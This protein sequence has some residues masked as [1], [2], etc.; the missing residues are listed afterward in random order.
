MQLGLL[1][2]QAGRALRVAIAAPVAAAFDPE[3]TR[4]AASLPALVRAFESEDDVEATLTIRQPVLV[5]VPMAARVLIVSRAGEPPR[6]VPIGTEPLLVGRA[7]SSD[8]VLPAEEVS[9]MHCRLVPGDAGLTVI[10]LQ[11][12][13][14]TSLDGQRVTAQ[15]V[16]LPNSE[17]RV[18]PYVLTCRLALTM[19][20]ANAATRSRRRGAG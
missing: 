14:G 16:M 1:E 19:P 12:T 7:P 4:L 15:S 5:P 18:G 2:R 17:L 3:L 13:N 11:S 6:E 8:V 20:P 10:D 9:R